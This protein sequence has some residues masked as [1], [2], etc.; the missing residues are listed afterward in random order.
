[1]ARALVLAVIAPDVASLASPADWR[2]SEALR[3]GRRV[4]AAKATASSA[5][6]RHRVVAKA[7]NEN[8]WA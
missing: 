4:S 2:E 5:R 1:M 6:G 8:G 7:P 3:S